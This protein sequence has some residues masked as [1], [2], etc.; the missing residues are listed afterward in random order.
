MQRRP[1]G[2]TGIEVSE[3][4]FGAWQLGND[5]DWGGMDDATAHAL[6]HRAL[7]LGIDLFD[8][9]PNYAGGRSQVL[10]GE[11]LRGRR[12]DVTIVSKFGHPPEGPKDFRVESFEP[13]L[14]ATLEALQ[15]DRL[16]VLVLHNPPEA[17]LR[18]DDPLWDA[19]EAARRVGRIRHYGVS[20]DFAHEMRTALAHTGSEVFEVLFNILHQDIRRAFDDAT[21]QGA[22]I[23]AKVPL[24]SGWL[25]GRFGSEQEFG[26]IRSR[27]TPEQVQERAD[28][29]R[30]LDWLT[31][32]GHSLTQPSLAYLLSYPAVSTVLPGMRTLAQL[33]DNAAASAYPFEHEARIRLERFW[34]DFTDGGTRLLPW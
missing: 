24:D 2:R 11:A 19:L 14:K 28:L 8:T 33:E 23:L 12:D 1:L 15:T 25:T 27:W 3:I 9:A 6:V 17:M 10:L 32:D 4:G 21:A 18:G 5:S 30:Q 7:E 13:T 34:E 31:S 16:D 22:G 29:V 20:L 26:G